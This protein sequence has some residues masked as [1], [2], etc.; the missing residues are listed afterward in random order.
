M[1]PRARLNDVEKRKLLTLPG[2][3]LKPL[4]HPARRQSLYR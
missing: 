1:D 4:D 3:E 2:L